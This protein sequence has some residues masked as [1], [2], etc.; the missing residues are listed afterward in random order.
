M[1]AKSLMTY[2][3][4]KW[5]LYSFFILSSLIA[6]SCSH[7]RVVVVDQ[8]PVAVDA[9]HLMRGPV[10]V[11]DAGHGGKD[12][13]TNSKT[14]HYEEKA[15]TLE[16]AFMLEHYLQKMGYRTVLTRSE[17]VFIPLS[18]RAGI[19]NDLR[20]RLFVS[21]H[22]NSAPSK[23]ASGIEVFYYLSDTNKKR[24]IESKNLGDHV[25]REVTGAT[26]AKSRGVKHGDFAVIRETKMPAILV[27]SGFL[28]NPEERQRILQRPYMQ[29]LARGVAKGVDDYL[30]RAK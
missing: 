20:S 15:L 30:K 28:T 17:D 24:T 27:E 21:M 16:T 6:A 5:R 9:P 11:I 18:K 22:Y 4:R 1:I 7:P 26:G 2:A 29:R 12:L 13:G 19:A 8:E 25:L 10:I 3:R 23:D 14:L